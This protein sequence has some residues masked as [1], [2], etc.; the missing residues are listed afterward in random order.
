MKITNVIKKFSKYIDIVAASISGTLAGFMTVVVLI[1]VFYRY[2]LGDAR[3]WSEE[4]A[5]YTMIWM[6]LL[7]ISVGVYRDQHVGLE[8]FVGLFPKKLQ[9]ACLYISRIF[10][11]FFMFILLYYGVP[12]ARRALFESAMTMGVPMI[13]FVASIPVGAFLTVLQIIFIFYLEIFGDREINIPLNKRAKR[14]EL[15]R[16]SKEGKQN[17]IEE[18]S[19]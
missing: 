15:R 12:M 3:V 5:R 2:V 4:L 6:V 10:M 9:I 18:V 16:L 8:L 1:G 14:D 19:L 17:E 7:T 13:L 11:L